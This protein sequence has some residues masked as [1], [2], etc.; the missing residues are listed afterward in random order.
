M[1]L[2]EVGYD[3]RDWINL[4][5]DRDRW[6]AYRTTL[7]DCRSVDEFGDSKTVFGEMR[8]SI[9][10]RLFDVHLSVGE[11]LGKKP[12]PDNQAKGKSNLRPKNRIGRQAP[13]LT[14]LTP[15]ANI[16]QH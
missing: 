8:P 9:R 2:R 4:A 6:R 13:Q 15:V 1:D 3:D 14:E 12:Q 5:Q 10:H 7:K 11:N 16:D